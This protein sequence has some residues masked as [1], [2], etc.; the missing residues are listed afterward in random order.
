VLCS[1]GLVVIATLTLAASAIRPRAIVPM[2]AETIVAQD[3]P[4][5]TARAEVIN[6]VGTVLGTAKFSQSDGGVRIELDV[7]QQVPGPHA[8]HIDSIGKCEGPD[9]KSAG[10][11]FNPY[12]KQHGSN[13]P[14]GPH[15]GD[16][17][18]FVAGLDGHAKVTLLAPLVTLGDGANSL[19]H[20]GATSLVIDEDP[21]D[22]KTDPDGNSGARIACG[23]VQK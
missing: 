12:S 15:A 2:A 8:I 21:D 17:S 7:V 9:F 22:Y 11:H 1:R 18:N 10:P 5:S 3:A 19:F 23:V 14:A 4:Q 16:L 6:S 13:N 20:P